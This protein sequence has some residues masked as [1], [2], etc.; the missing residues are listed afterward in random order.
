[1]PVFLEKLRIKI[2]QREI[3]TQWPNNLEKGTLQ[4]AGV[5]Q[6]LIHAIH[7]GFEDDWRIQGPFLRVDLD[8]WKIPESEWETDEE[9]IAKF[10]ARLTQGEI[11]PPVVIDYLGNFIDG[12]HRHAAARL[13]RKTLRCLIQI[14]RN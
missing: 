11:P 6:R 10:L 3:Q 7:P 4:D 9:K 5:V 13:A 1:M 12:G 14:H 2:P 8:P